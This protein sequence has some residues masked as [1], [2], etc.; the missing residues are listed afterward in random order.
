MRNIKN[1]IKNPKK[2][3]LDP[4]AKI[5]VDRKVLRIEPEKTIVIVS[6]NAKENKIAKIE[7]TGAKVIRATT[8]NGSFEMKKIIKTLGK[9]GIISVLIEGGGNTNAKAL[10]AGIVDK[11]YFFVAPKIIGG[12]EAI[13]PIE[14]EGITQLL[15]AIKIKN[16]SIEKSGED[17]LFSGYLC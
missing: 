3:I 5:D 8:K 17:F 16:L 2:I 1:K 4:L 6:N 12:K 14:G 11:I 13:T 9:M 10:S 7:S 15:K